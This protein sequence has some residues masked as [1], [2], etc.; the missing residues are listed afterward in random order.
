M[1]DFN[2]RDPTALLDRWRVEGLRRSSGRT[3]DPQDRGYLQP[4]W[5]DGGAEPP[6]DGRK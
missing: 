5:L 1:D 3:S 6:S 2:F 4:R